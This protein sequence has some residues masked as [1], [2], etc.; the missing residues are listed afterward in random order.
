MA[1]PIPAR[2]APILLL[3]LFLALSQLACTTTRS[4]S[5][6]GGSAQYSMGSL[7]AILARPLSWE[8]LDDLEG[9]LDRSGPYA[10]ARDRNEARL[11]LAEGRA[12][13]ARQDKGSTSAAVLG[14][15]RERA[16][17]DFQLVL[18]DAGA[19]SAQRA[20]AKNGISLLG[21]GSTT[22]ASVSSAGSPSNLGI[23]SRAA[24]GASPEV[25]RH[26]SRHVAPWSKITVHHTAMPLGASSSRA[27]RCG[28][29]RTIQRAHLN[30]PE[31]WGDVGYHYLIDPEGRIYEGR[32]LAWRGAHVAGKND[33]NLGVCLLGNFDEYRPTSAA[34]ASLERLLDDLRTRHRIPRNQVTY[35]KEWPSANTACPGHH[36][37]PWVESYRGGAGLA[38]HHTPST[39]PRPSAPRPSTGGGV[40]R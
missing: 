34:L 2:R 26:M 7:S 37:A 33:H 31:G 16:R 22:T 38:F 9:W 10:S 32:R 20:R 5:S 3:L 36:L 19:S 30:K 25:P 14:M 35:H 8:K 21:S 39:T 24:W 1:D 40:V 11:A 13:F 28:E 15:R 29:L 12:S 27:A 17:S 4:S 18:A 23:I 6:S